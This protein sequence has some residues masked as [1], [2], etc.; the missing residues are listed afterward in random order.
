MFPV[1]IE[2]L[3]SRA[4]AL[5]DEQKRLVIKQMPDRMLWDEVIARYIKSKRIVRNTE[6][7]MR[8]R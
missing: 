1:E 8:M 2:E 3:S 6:K 5:T 7:A 4:K